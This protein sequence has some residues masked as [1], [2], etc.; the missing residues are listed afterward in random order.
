MGQSVCVLLCE[1]IIVLCLS[2]FPC[3]SHIKVLLTHLLTYEAETERYFNG[4][5]SISSLVLIS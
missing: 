5:R 2:F 1:I 3:C 4:L